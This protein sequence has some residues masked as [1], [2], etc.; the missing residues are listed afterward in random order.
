MKKINEDII[1]NIDRLA[2]ISFDILDSE[3]NNI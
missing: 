2:N 1:T 3:I